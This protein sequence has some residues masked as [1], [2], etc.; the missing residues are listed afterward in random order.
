MIPDFIRKAVNRGWNSLRDSTHN[1]LNSARALCRRRWNSL[2]EA[3]NNRLDAL[4]QRLDIYLQ[5]R[6]PITS[7]ILRKI[8]INSQLIL[9]ESREEIHFAASK[10]G[11]TLVAAISDT[12]GGFFDVAATFLPSR[13]NPI[14][15]TFRAIW[16]GNLNGVFFRGVGLNVLF[17]GVGTLLVRGPDIVLRYAMASPKVL[18]LDEFIEDEDNAAGPKLYYVLLVSNLLVAYQFRK[19]IKEIS[20]I[21]GKKCLNFFYEDAFNNTLINEHAMRSEIKP[22]LSSDSHIQLKELC[23][24]K[25]LLSIDPRPAALKNLIRFKIFSS[26]EATAKDLIVLSLLLF[27][28][29]FIGSRLFTVAGWLLRARILGKDLGA[30]QLLAMGISNQHLQNIQGHRNF[31]FLGEGIAYFGAYDA[32][33]RICNHYLGMNDPVFNLAIANLVY[34]FCIVSNYM[35]IWNLREEDYKEKGL[36]FSSVYRPHLIDP[37]IDR[38]A[39][40]I[41][42]RIRRREEE[43]AEAPAIVKLTQELKLS[44]EV[45]KSKDGEEN[46]DNKENKE[47]EKISEIASEA[48]PQQ[49]LAQAQKKSAEALWWEDIFKRQLS[50]A[51]RDILQIH[52]PNLIFVL[53]TIRYKRSISREMLENFLGLIFPKRLLEIIM[54]ISNEITDERI[55]NLI[56]FLILHQKSEFDE[57]VYFHDDQDKKLFTEALLEGVIT[58]E[59]SYNK[60]NVTKIHEETAKLMA[61]WDKAIIDVDK[62]DEQ[63]SPDGVLN[64]LVSAQYETVKDEEEIRTL[65]SPIQS[66]PDKLL[67]SIRRPMIQFLHNLSTARSNGTNTLQFLADG[68]A[69]GVS[70][71][72]RKVEDNVPGGTTTLKVA[73]LASPIVM[74][75]AVGVGLGLSAAAVSTVAENADEI[76]TGV[77]VGANVVTAVAVAAESQPLGLSGSFSS[78]YNRAQNSA[79]GLRDWLY[80]TEKDKK[81]ESKSKFT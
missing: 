63:E 66:I 52:A 40:R 6:Y 36:N 75:G 25:R 44:K 38:I 35:K 5:G 16:S 68:T 13:Q 70:S 58:S 46:K 2:R 71:L 33:Q 53:S 73:A 57:W 18:S 14:P 76:G 26:M 8:G 42:S 65:V 21:L 72:K 49:D 22:P 62:V 3:T 48:Q 11:T 15:L 55:D 61:C 23:D 59:L 50:S 81:P 30:S 4:A 43:R 54:S 79:T 37:A 69:E 17:V 56:R 29:V 67:E 32:V 31:R 78:L 45:Q 34:K 1:R 64:A 20:K 60:I 10:L 12:V 51:E 27:N 74:G 77:R 7:A 80:A 19:T 9:K 28:H 24:Q 41:E 47:N 39:L